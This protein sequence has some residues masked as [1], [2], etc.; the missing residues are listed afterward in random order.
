[1]ANHKVPS[2]SYLV[3]VGMIL[4]V[5]GCV[6]VSSPAIAGKS[7]VIIIGVILVAAGVTQIVHGVGSKSWSSKAL[8]LV[9]GAIAIL[10]GLAV[11]A[12]PWLGLTVLTVIMAV[13]FVVEGVWKIIAS[14]RFRPAS[15]WLAVLASGVIGLLLGLLIWAQ[16]PLSDL[17]AVGIL[18]GIDLIG[19]GI[20]L[21]TLAWTA[22][23]LRSA[24]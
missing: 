22:R 10:A 12:H 2:T 13:Y 21:L 18:V 17:L 11:L 6:A 23:G 4:L 16:W 8:S 14:F 24:A 19:T 1:M 15:G 5:L 20:A 9:L 3:L 7:V